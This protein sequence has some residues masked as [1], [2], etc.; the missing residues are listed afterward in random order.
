MKLKKFNAIL[1][2]A[3]IAAV[4]C[5]AGTMT[6][7]LITFWYDLTICKFFAHLSVALMIAHI[8]TSICIFFFLHDGSSLRYSRM[9]KR[10][11]IQRV[12]AV[13]MIIL[14]HF[15][16]TAYSHMATGEALSQSQAIISCLT[17]CL[18]IISVFLHTSVS[19]SKA[20]TTLGLISSSKAAKRLDIAAFTVCTAAGIVAL[21]AVISFFLGDIL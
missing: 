6:Y 1:G 16:I 21:Y 5:H 11:I 15:H 20:F 13:L 4:L 9:N 10:T 12:T 2:L 8:L 3:I 7:S 17:E 19:F 14:I 18:Y